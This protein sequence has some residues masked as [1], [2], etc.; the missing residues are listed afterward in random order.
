LP[1]RNRG[2]HDPSVGVDGFWR[3]VELA[4]VVG[5]DLSELRKLV[6]YWF[7]DDY[8]QLAEAQIVVGA[9]NTGALISELLRLGAGNGPDAEAAWLAVDGADGLDDITYAVGVLTPEKVAKVAEFL[10]R[11][12]PAAWMQQ[13]RPQL[14]DYCRELGHVA[15][16]DDQWAEVVVTD[17]KE[18][19]QLFRLAAAAGEV[20]VVGVWA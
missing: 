6:P 15:P 12:D 9:E 10:A 4:A 7:D 11:V 5:L 8:R 17:T 18:L 13:F 20:V 19:T 14:A 3:R 2:W 16:F 1:D